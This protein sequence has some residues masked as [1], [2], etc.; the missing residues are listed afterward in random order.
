MVHALQR[1]LAEIGEVDLAVIFGSTARGTAQPGADVDLAL[2]LQGGSSAHL[3][4]LAVA[5]ERALGRPVDALDIDRAPPLLRFEIARSGRV[6]VERIAHGWADFRA[7]AMLDWWDWAPTA[8]RI[9]RRAVS[10][11]PRRGQDGAG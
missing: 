4:S 9:H 5:L 6:L 7:R 8:R 11:L 1:Q 2:R 3:A 10:R